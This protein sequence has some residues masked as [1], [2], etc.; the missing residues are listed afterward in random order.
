LVRSGSGGGG[1][2][3]FQDASIRASG[4]LGGGQ[5]GS[6]YQSGWAVFGIQADA[7]AAGIHGATGC[8]PEVANIVGVIS[9]QQSCSTKI[10]ALGAVAGRFGGAFDHTLYYV[11]AGFACEHERLEN[12]AN[13]QTIVG[14]TIANAEFSGTRYGATTGAGI[15]HAIGTNWTAFLQYNYMGFARDP[16][17]AAR[18]GQFQRRHCRT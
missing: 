18:V 16:L 14:P 8:F 13:I 2:P 11:L 1:P 9:S 15:E 12:A 7:D 17:I 4:V 3:G 5:I 6:D 10:D